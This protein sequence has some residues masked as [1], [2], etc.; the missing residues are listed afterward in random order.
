MRGR[1]FVRRRVRRLSRRRRRI[2]AYGVSRGGIR[3]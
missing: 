1:R 3:L 2:R